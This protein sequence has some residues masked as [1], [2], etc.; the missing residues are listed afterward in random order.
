MQREEVLKVASLARLN[1]SEAEI[2][3]FR[4]QLTDI[5]DYVETLQEVDV[6]GVEPM[7]HA[8]DVSNVFRDDEP[9]ESLPREA[10]LANAPKTDGRC[11]L[12]PRILDQKN[13]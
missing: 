10:A 9:G 2:E 12:V 4:L 7:P 5:L 11:F 1:L 13:A 3:A 6:D 8:V